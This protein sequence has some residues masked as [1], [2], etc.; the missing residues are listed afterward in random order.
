MSS[1]SDEGTVVAVTKKTQDKNSKKAASKTEKSSNGNVEY[2]IKPAKGGPTMD[3]STWPLLLK[4]G[5]TSLT[6]SQF[7]VAYTLSHP[8]KH[9]TIRNSR[10]LF[11]GMDE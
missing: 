8:V 10:K 3:T 6:T 2:Q 1:S 5:P 9:A 11:L 7:E 4:V